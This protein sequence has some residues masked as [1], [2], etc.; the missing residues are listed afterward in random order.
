MN[1]DA[2]SSVAEVIAAIGVIISLIYLAKQIRAQVEESRHA[3]AHEIASGWREMLQPLL[4]PDF[5]Q[6]FVQAN[7]DF[8]SLTEAQR[9]QIIAQQQTTFRLWEEAFYQYRGGRLNKTIWDPMVKQYQS[10]ISIAAFQRVWELRRSAYG[11]EFVEFVD[12]L[13]RLEY[14]TK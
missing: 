13:A 3:A 11:D 1:W 6:L 8:D 14:K 12:G 5:A 10:Y 7:A 2:I 9:I 4:D